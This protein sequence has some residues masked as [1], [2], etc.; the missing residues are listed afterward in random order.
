MVI[1]LSISR[2]LLG[3]RKKLS[4]YYGRLSACGKGQLACDVSLS[5][6]GVLSAFQMGLP[7][8]KGRLAL[9]AVPF[10]LAPVL[11]ALTLSFGTAACSTELAAGVAFPRGF[12]DYGLGAHV[13]LEGLRAPLP[14]F[15]NPGARVS[16]YLSYRDN[17]RLTVGSL[18][19]LLKLKAPRPLSG[20]L[21]FSPYISAGPSFNY[22]YSWV[23]LQDFGSM[24]ESD[25]STTL[26]VFVGAEFFSATRMTLFAEARQ[27]IPSDF[28]FDY[29]LVGLKVRGPTL[30]GID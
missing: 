23:D 1:S 12:F 5:V 7:A 19:L 11:I 17:V 25:L 3:S 22:L 27:T 18:S 15:L 4:T 20:T 16:G 6:Y 14:A 26:S 28:T 13:E 8:I 24:S 21:G 30:P 10:C 29:V 9:R 2:K